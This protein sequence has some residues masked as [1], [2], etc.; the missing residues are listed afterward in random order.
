MKSFLTLFAFSM[1][2]GAGSGASA[3]ACPSGDVVLL[4][5]HGEAMAEIDLR[6]NHVRVVHKDVELRRIAHSLD[7]ENDNFKICGTDD[8]ILDE[9]AN[10]QAM[11]VILIEQPTSTLKVE[12]KRSWFRHYRWT[13]TNFAIRRDCGMTLEND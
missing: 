1:G 10:D 12:V 3:A 4:Q 7:G 6:T 9:C 5:H 13:V 8:S 2:L 11:P